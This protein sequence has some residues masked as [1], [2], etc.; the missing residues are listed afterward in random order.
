MSI[1]PTVSSGAGFNGFRPVIIAGRFVL[2]APDN[3]YWS[4]GH[5]SHFVHERAPLL[6]PPMIPQRGKP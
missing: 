1:D 5:E 4:Q 3:D 2:R 6:H